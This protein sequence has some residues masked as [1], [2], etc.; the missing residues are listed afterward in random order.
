VEADEIVQLYTRQLSASLTRP[1]RELKAFERVTLK[2]GETRT[3]RFTL[4][5]SSLAFHNERGEL[6]TEPGLFHV[7]VAPDSSRGQRS[8]FRLTD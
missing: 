6:V 2:P 4:S 5:T 3:V 7:W 8:E 1:V